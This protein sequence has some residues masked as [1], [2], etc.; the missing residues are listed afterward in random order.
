M[1]A[2]QCEKS[3]DLSCAS[4]FQLVSAALSPSAGSDSLFE[5]LRATYFPKCEGCGSV[6]QV[7]VSSRGDDQAS[8]TYFLRVWEGRQLKA[9]G[10]K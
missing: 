7:K 6:A 2:K 1:G 4:S 3:C 10:S 8:D 9:A 5:E